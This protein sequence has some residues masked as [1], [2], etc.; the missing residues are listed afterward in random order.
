M[1]WRNIDF[2]VAQVI[3]HTI[4]AYL[5][6]QL[7]NFMFSLL[8]LI[9]AV[10]QKEMRGPECSQNVRVIS[11]SCLMRFRQN[12]IGLSSSTTMRK[13]LPHRLVS[14]NRKGVRTRF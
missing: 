6:F 9:S 4:H 8:I 1:F 11:A 3:W 5:G 2:K 7:P 13:K 10:D 14:G 12:G